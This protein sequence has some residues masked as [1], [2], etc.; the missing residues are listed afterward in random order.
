[1]Q[2]RTDLAL[3]A[4]EQLEKEGISAKVLKLNRIAPLDMAA[5]LRET[6][7]M[8]IVLVLEDCFETGS[9]GQQIAA[10]ME[11]AGQ[12]HAHVILQNL[13]DHFAPE[14]TVEQLQHRFGLDA[15]GAAGAVKEAIGR[16]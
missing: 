16:E 6:E 10:G 3:E 5:V 7:G 8:D 9:V 13:K 11:E 14:G 2:I 12:R 15:D 4:A 1:M